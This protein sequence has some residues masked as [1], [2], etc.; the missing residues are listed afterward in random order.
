MAGIQ[1]AD[2]VPFEYGYADPHISAD[3][4]GNSE[5]VFDAGVTSGVSVRLGFG[6]SYGAYRIASANR[7]PIEGMVLGAFM[8]DFY[9]RIYVE[10]AAI[11]LGNLVSAQQR[12]VTVWNAYPYTAQTLLDTPLIGGDG[13]DITTP[14][15]LPLLFRPLQ[16][17]A[18]ELTVSTDGPPVIDAAWTFNFASANDVTVTITGSRITPWAWLPDWRDGILERLTWLTDVLPSPIRSEQRRSLRQAP[19]RSF[20]WRTIVDAQERAQLDLALYS[21]GARIWA[22]PVWPDIYWLGAALPLASTLVPCATTGRDFRA[23][24][25]ALLRAPD[26]G[27]ARRYEVVEIDSVEPTGLQLINPT[28]Q[29]WPRG[30]RLYPLRLAKLQQQPKP[31]RLTDTAWESRILMQVMEPSDWPA[32]A[33]AVT[34]RGWPV[35]EAAPDETEEW[36]GDYERMVLELEN[37]TGFPRDTDTAGTPA[38]LQPHRWVLQDRSQQGAFRSLLYYF[39]GRFKSAWVPTF[40]AD[41]TPVSVIGGASTTV[42]VSAVD[43]VR[44]GLGRVGR[45]DIRIEMWDGTS[46]YRRIADASTLDFDTERLAIDSALGV[47]VQPSQVRRISFLALCRLNADAVEIQHVTD[48]DGV[49]QAM[50]VFRGIRDDV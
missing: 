6:G 35:L 50:V 25:L 12:T 49:A 28:V 4:D 9:F 16:E 1:G 33:P 26:Y 23:G 7:W 10:P 15:P 5:T 38:T 39:R 46:Y 24:G 11:E 36:S 40:A 22:M 32:A 3:L 8:Q 19:G 18:W 17:R 41:L 48:A 43:Y 20:E 44:F 14:G 42:D 27:Q 45:R 37:A 29:A 13:I 34:Y 31:R 2:L 21:W 47:T 30:T